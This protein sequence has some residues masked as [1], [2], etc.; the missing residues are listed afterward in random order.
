MKQ[1]LFGILLGILLPLFSVQAQ[2]NKL[3]ESKRKSISTASSDNFFK[4]E[5]LFVE[6]QVGF[7]LSNTGFQINFSPYVGYSFSDKMAAGIGVGY[8]YAKINSYLG[9]SI[10]Y[11]ANIA[12]GSVFAELSPFSDL[13]G[14]GTTI[15]L[16]GEFGYA[17]YK[18]PNLERR[19]GDWILPVGGG[20]RLAT[21]GVALINMNIMYNLLHKEDSIFGSGFIYQPSFRWYFLR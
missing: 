11:S 8:Q 5:N 7:N 14:R 10:D 9:Q 4:K 18:E 2:G 1:L 3:P 17:S 21:G 12:T 19:I 15:Y 13:L 20:I 6:P 16:R